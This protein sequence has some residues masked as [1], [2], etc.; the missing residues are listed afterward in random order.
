MMQNI[1]KKVH[2]EKGRK[3]MITYEEFKQELL[4]QIQETVDGK[5]EA[6]ITTVQKNNQSEKEGIFIRT[7]NMNMVPVIYLSD[8]YQEYINGAAIEKCVEEVIE[9][10]REKS[11]KI[12]SVFIEWEVAKEWLQVNL[13]NRKWNE[14]IIK[15]MPHREWCDLAMI[16]RLVIARAEYGE[17]SCNVTNRMLEKWG[18]SQQELWE[19]AEQK[20]QEE[21]YA[22]EDIMTLISEV[23]DVPDNELFGNQY[24]LTNAEKRY[25]AGGILRSDI[26]KNFAE[27]TGGSYYILPSSIHETILVPDKGDIMAEELKEMVKEVNETQVTREEWLSESVYYYDCET[28]DVEML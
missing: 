8:L 15:D 28:G 19:A 6:Y 23:C 2:R 14:E 4:E 16:C 5:T 1:Q 7:Q 3:I 26:L 21:E 24:V 22:V 11:Y 13:I 9:I 27:E 10:V 25:G 18:I 12:P 17:A 20:L